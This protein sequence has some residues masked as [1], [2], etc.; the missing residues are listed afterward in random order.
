[1]Y[2]PTVASQADVVLHQLRVG[3]CPF[4]KDKLRRW[5]RAEE[6]GLFDACVEAENTKY[7]I[8]DC[9]K[10]TAARIIYLG[11]RPHISVLQEDPEGVV[12]F[13]RA[14]GLLRET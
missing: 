4:Q 5:R 11:P 7:F 3:R 9:I 1:M 13:V 8:T 2:R 10:C 6:D 12:R 14:T